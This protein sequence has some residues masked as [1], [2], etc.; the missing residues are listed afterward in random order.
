MD[1]AAKRLIYERNGAGPPRRGPTGSL[2]SSSD[3]EGRRLIIERNTRYGLGKA[4]T[5]T[6]EDAQLLA[7]MRTN[8]QARAVLGAIAQ[9]LRTAYEQRLP[10]YSRVGSAGQQL[11]AA[12]K[13]RLDGINNYAQRVYA[14]IPGDDAPISATTQAKVA[15]SLA[16]TRDA[17]NDIDEAVHSQHISIGDV[18]QG[19][20]DILTYLVKTALGAIGG[21]VLPGG[22]KLPTA[23]KI[24]IGG[25]VLLV[26][27]GVAAKL[28][29]TIM[30]SEASALGDAE[31][32][33]VALAEAERRK[34]RKR[35]VLTIS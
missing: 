4:S 31:A 21:A 34:R 18:A 16:Q 3:P 25:I 11:A 26:I 5:L 23:V 35:R 15:L 9:T 20:A 17:A 14:T 24:A 33:A 19:M 7:G 10:F 22:G 13:S 6:P 1:D 28:V 30:F 29:H 2:G 32:A 8:R 12:M 27:V